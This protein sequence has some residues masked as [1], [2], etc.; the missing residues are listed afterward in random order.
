MLRLFALQ[1]YSQHP[2]SFIFIPL[3]LYHS[4]RR[5]PHSRPGPRISSSVL[6]YYPVQHEAIP[7]AILGTDVVCQAKSGM[8]KT[9]VF[10]T[11]L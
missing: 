4:F 6:T 10:G 3:F 1:H 8:G 5:R 9:A 2:L 11:F 7:Q